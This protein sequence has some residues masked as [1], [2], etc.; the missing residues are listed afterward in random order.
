M[1]VG[2]FF[3]YVCAAALCLSLM[4]CSKEGPTGPA[5][6]AGAPGAP[7]PGTRIVYEGTVTAAANT[8]DGQAIS[9]PEL[10][11]G[12]FPLVAVYISNGPGI[13]VQCNLISIT[14]TNDLL[15]YEMAYIQNGWITLYSVME[16]EQYRIVIVR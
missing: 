10:Q 5:G 12:S 16:G 1:P 3:R 13:W 6:P 9:V 2:R 15:I 4:S 8:D 11:L 14:P 7:G